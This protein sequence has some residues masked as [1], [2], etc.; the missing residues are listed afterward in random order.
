VTS[1]TSWLV[2]FIW[3]STLLSDNALSY[4]ENTPKATLQSRKTFHDTRKRTFDSAFQKGS[5]PGF[6]HSLKLDTSWLNDAVFK[7]SNRW[8]LVFW[9]LR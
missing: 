7:G 2:S 1:A 4:V 5:V 9:A 6:A 3:L 8:L